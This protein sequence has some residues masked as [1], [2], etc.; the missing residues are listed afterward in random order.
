[1][2]DQYKKHTEVRG[3]DRVLE[4]EKAADLE[5]ATG[6]DQAADILQ[7]ARARDRRITARAERR[8]Q[9]LHRHIQAEIE[10]EKGRMQRAFEKQRREITRPPAPEAITAAAQRLARRLAGVGSS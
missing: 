9:N 1:M 4:A 8:L 10:H 5:I 7:A 2:P 3:F 6:H